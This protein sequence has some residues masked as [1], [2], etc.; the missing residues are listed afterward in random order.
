MEVVAPTNQFGELYA[1]LPGV[2]RPFR[3]PGVDINEALPEDAPAFVAR[4]D[5]NHERLMLT[6]QGAITA[7]SSGFLP[8]ITVPA[9]APGAPVTIGN[10]GGPLD[11]AFD[12]Y[13]VVLDAAAAVTGDRAPA[14]VP[15][16]DA[17]EFTV[18]AANLQNFRATEPD[19]EGRVAKAARYVIDILRAP[20]ILGVIEVG[21]LAD[22]QALAASINAEAATS[23][24]AYLEDGDGTTPADGFEQ[25]VG[26]LVNAA[27]VQVLGTEQVFRG[28][29]FT[30]AGVT[31]LLHDRPPFILEA[32][33]IDGG[34]PVTVIVNHLKSLIGVNSVAPY[35]GSAFTEGQRNREKRRLQAEDLAD[36]VAAHVHGNLVVMGDMNAFEFNDGLV[37]VVDTIAGEPAAAETVVSPSPDRWSH[38]LVNLAGLLPASERYSYVFDGH[39][40]VLDHILVSPAM[41]QLVSRVAYSRANADFPVSLGADSSSAMRLSD[42]D[43]PVAFFTP[44]AD[45]MVSVTAAAPQVAAG[46]SAAFTVTVTNQGTTPA[47]HVVVTDGAAAIATYPVLAAGASEAVTFTRAATCEMTDGLVLAGVATVSAD[48]VDPDASNNTAAAL[49]TVANAAPAIAGAVVS[50]GTLWPPA[51]RLVPVH[52]SYSAADDCGAVTTTLSVTS[53]EPVTAP[54]RAQ[55]LAGLTAPDWRVIDADTVLLRAERSVRGDGRVYTITITATD[56]AGG[57]ATETVTVG[58]PRRGHGWRDEH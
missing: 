21:T 58:V 27:R 36:L 32:R 52:V 55:G 24:T 33:M 25:N 31:D 41:Q 3:E 12:T 8:F 37:D 40:Q 51:Y 47:Q 13:R 49:V 4:F 50:R 54:V 44:R 48:T 7:G 45:L 35:A 5:G 57:T 18:A 30:F 9:G 29:Q 19:F 22:L 1:V 10:V 46:A 14:A 20:D 42:H 6:R 17:G 43:T 39:A 16:A 11:Y 38:R 23:Y 26:Y 56:A 53:D 34:T 2:A 15:P 28:K